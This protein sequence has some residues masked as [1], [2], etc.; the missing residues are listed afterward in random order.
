MAKETNWLESDRILEYDGGLV[1]R[2]P[3]GTEA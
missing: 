2:N 3:M 1:V